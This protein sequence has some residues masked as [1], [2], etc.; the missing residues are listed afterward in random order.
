MLRAVQLLVLLWIVT[1]NFIHEHFG[2]C[3]QSYWQLEC[4]EYINAALSWVMYYVQQLRQLSYTGS[5]SCHFQS[6]ITTL[7]ACLLSRGVYCTGTLTWSSSSCAT[8][9]WNTGRTS[10]ALTSSVSCIVVWY[11]YSSELYNYHN[12]AERTTTKHVL[13]LWQLVVTFGAQDRGIIIRGV[14]SCKNGRHCQL[15]AF[16]FIALALQVG[17]LRRIWARPWPT[18]M[19]FTLTELWKTTSTR[20]F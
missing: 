6:Y 4:R 17:S 19:I 10:A 14:E 12:E 16:N 3:I 20:C 15:V 13:V 2:K 18:G 9:T 11:Y 5:G 7:S 1:W 8:W